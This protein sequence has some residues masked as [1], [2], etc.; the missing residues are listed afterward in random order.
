MAL[1]FALKESLWESAPQIFCFFLIFFGLRSREIL[2]LV[3]MS[4][5]LSVCV[6]GSLSKVSYLNHLTSLAGFSIEFSLS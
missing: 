5:H 4:I 2:H 3:T 1:I 6:S